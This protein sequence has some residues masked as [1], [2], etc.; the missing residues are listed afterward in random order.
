MSDRPISTALHI[1]LA[2]QEQQDE[3][4]YRYAR[5]LHQNCIRES[6]NK[7]KCVE[8][9]YQHFNRCQSNN[10]QKYKLK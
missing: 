8:D 9:F 5:T 2:R 10:S 6:N 3:S 1:S 7:T 4:C